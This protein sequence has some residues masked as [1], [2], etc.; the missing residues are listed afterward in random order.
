MENLL[1]RLTLDCT[2]IKLIEL[3]WTTSFPTL[4]M[5]LGNFDGINSSGKKLNA[6]TRVFKM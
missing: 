5:E 3:H 2:R 6:K 4:A 1:L